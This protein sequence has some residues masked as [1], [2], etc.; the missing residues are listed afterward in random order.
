[1]STDISSITSPFLLQTLKTI[2][3]P[4]VNTIHQA[5]IKCRDWAF[6]KDIQ[7]NPQRIHILRRPQVT[8]IIPPITKVQEVNK[9]PV[10]LPIRNQATIQLQRPT[11]NLRRYIKLID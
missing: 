1:M 8:N 10:K 11:R 5:D 9:E 7:L 3:Q 6:K 4:Q 2:I